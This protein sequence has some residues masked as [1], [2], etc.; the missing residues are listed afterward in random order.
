MSDE[1]IAGM[2][3]TLNDRALL[4]GGALAQ[5]AMTGRAVTIHERPGV[6]RCLFDIR[7]DD[8]V[9]SVLFKYSTRRKS[10]WYFTV[11]REQ[12]EALRNRAPALPPSRR[13]FAL[14]CHIDG[15]CL[16]SLDDF[17]TAVRIRRDDIQWGVSVSRPRSAQYHVSGPG[18]RALEGAIPRSRWTTEFF[19]A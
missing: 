7:T 19:N 16:I 18:R 17:C 13:Y 5:L 3:G 1:Q 8:A 15:V 14:V 4:M 12:L 11:T 2:A 10:P 9:S 6:E